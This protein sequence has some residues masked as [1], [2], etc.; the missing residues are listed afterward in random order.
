MEIKKKTKEY[1]DN[2]ITNERKE[3]QKKR[4]QR[5]EERS[6]KISD[7]KRAIRNGRKREKAI[8]EE[9]KTHAK[10]VERREPKE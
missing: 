1:A 6:E 9:L 7:N 5:K 2:E 4:N 3:R 10:K 8:K